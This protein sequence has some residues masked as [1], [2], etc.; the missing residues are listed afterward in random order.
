MKNNKNI[1]HEELNNRIDLAAAY[2][3]ADIYGFS[4]IIWNHI[5]CKTSSKKNTFLINKFGLRY[6]EVTASN[7]LEVDLDGNIISGE[8]EIN[9][10]GFVIHGAIHKNREDLKCIM[11]SHSRYGLALSCLKDGLK[12]LI[13]DSA[14]FYNKISYHD[15]EG[16]STSTEEC[17]SLTKDLG[18]NN[19]MILR[20]HGLLT[21]GKTVGETFMLMYYLDRACK[22]QIDL[23]STKKDIIT[24]S[25][26]LLKF[27]AGQYE[28]PKYQ[29]GKH[30]WPALK[31]MLNKNNSIYDQ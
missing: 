2:H 5:T 16:M 25:D 10:T 17:E 19:I 31:R 18:V 11:H 7:L 12:I 30:E 26:N 9:Y 6:D 29:L 28:D 14:M 24:P 15:W 3:L 13:Q 23:I 27:S 22:V 1:D 8:G 4:D 20:N 21:A